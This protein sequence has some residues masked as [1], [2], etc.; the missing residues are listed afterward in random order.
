MPIQFR[1]LAYLIVTV[2]AY[3]YTLYLAVDTTGY[4]YTLMIIP[5]LVLAVYL[6]SEVDRMLPDYPEPESEPWTDNP[7]TKT[8]DSKNPWSHVTSDS[9]ANIRSLP[10]S[11]LES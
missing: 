6:L 9:N 2:L 1:Y 10:S 8:Q 5:E 3:V 7:S 4:F 11:R